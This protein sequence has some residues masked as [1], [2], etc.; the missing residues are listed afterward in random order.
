[1]FAIIM[2][3]SPCLEVESL[4]LTAGTFGWDN[5]LLLA[6]VYALISVAG[7]I[8]LVMLAFKGV[9]MLN[10]H[11]IEHHEKRITGMVLILVGVVTFYLH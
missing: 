8:T 6:L 3:L 7:I 9:T 11:F 4:F 10:W 2:F 5:I 1:M